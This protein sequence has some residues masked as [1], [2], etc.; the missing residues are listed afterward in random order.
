MVCFNYSSVIMKINTRLCYALKILSALA[1]G[2]KGTLRTEPLSSSEIAAK[3]NISKRYADS[4]LSI[5]SRGGLVD[6]H[7]GVSGGY[8]LKKP[9][10]DITLYEVFEILEGRVLSARCIDKKNNC[11]FSSRCSGHKIFKSLEEK[12]SDSLRKTTIAD[13]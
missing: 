6:A 12:I 7:Q 5:L 4:I 2:Y 3:E 1:S 13:L 9:P 8:T 11:R 10:S